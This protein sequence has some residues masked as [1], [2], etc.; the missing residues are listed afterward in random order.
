AAAE[1]ALGSARTA[2]AVLGADGSSDSRFSLRAPIGGVVLEREG[3][4]GQSVAPGAALF[5]IG[6]LSTLWL[7]AHAFERDAVRIRAGVEARVSFAAL[8]GQTFSGQVVRIGGAVDAG[9]RTL[10]I[11]LAVRNPDG[12]LRP[13]MSANL[14]LPLGDAGEPLVS[15]PAAAVQRLDAGWVVF[16]PR[17]QGRFEVRGVGRGRDLGEEVEILNGLAPGETVVVD[18]AFLL[19]AEMEKRGGSAEHED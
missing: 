8:P 16:L 3:A 7:I 17:E 9:S 5:K 10:P 14:W 1:A 19:K 2:L 11:R 12:V 13:G 15:V 6:D 4:A 18:G